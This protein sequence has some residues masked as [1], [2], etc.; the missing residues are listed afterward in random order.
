MHRLEAECSKLEQRALEETAARGVGQD[1]QEKL[2]YLDETHTAQRK[3]NDLQ[4]R[5]KLM[6]NCLAEKDTI[7]RALQGQKRKNSSIENISIAIFLIF[8]VY[9]GAVVN[10]GSYSLLSNNDCYTT[11]ASSVVSSTPTTPLIYN[12]SNYDNLMTQ[13]P[14]SSAGSSI[15]DYSGLQLANQLYHHQ[16]YGQKLSGQ[17]GSSN[18]GS[19]LNQVA[20]GG[21]VN[22]GIGKL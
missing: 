10:T 1:N 22:I 2:R 8:L 21:V 16:N 6:E 19:L 3:V 20:S 15:L 13:V 4:T 5:L 18:N 12:P 17:S 9:S 11:S 14:S 7:I